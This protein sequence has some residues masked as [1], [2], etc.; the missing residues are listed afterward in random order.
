MHNIKETRHLTHSINVL[1]IITVMILNIGILSHTC[2]NAL[3]LSS[4]KNTL[5][6]FSLFGFVGKINLPSSDNPNE[7]KQLYV[8]NTNKSKNFKENV[9]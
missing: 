4:E 9:H 1:Q 3:H 8:R 7:V 5:G 6:H 2:F